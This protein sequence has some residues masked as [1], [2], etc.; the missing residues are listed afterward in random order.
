[1]HSHRVV[2]WFHDYADDIEAVNIHYVLTALDEKPDWNHARATRYMPLVDR[3]LR[4]K[5]LKLPQFILDPQGRPSAHYTLHYYFEVWQGGDRHYS[6]L[7]SEPVVTKSSDVPGTEPDLRDGEEDRDEPLALTRH[8]PC[9]K[10][11]SSE[12]RKT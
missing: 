7:Y 11:N 9:D 3:T 2:K 1:M 10:V 5:E 6:P 4:M 8:E 12:E